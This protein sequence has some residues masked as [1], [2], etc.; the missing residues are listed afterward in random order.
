M[1]KAYD[2][3]QSKVSNT[4]AS[5]PMVEMEFSPSLLPRWLLSSPSFSLGGASYLLK[6]GREG[7]SGH[8]LIKLQLKC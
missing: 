6:K 1:A 8:N 4:R 7:I 3:I 5:L 2:A